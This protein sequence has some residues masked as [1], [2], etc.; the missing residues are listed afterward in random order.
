MTKL[1]VARLV[2]TA[3][4]IIPATQRFGITGAAAAVTGVYIFPMMPFDVYLVIQSV[5]TSL[6][7]LLRELSYPAVASFLMGGVVFWLQ[8]VLTLE[9]AILEFLILATVG[10]VIYGVAVAVLETQLRWG[11]RDTLGTFMSSI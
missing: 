10:A 4:V 5:E 7:R 9:W 2:L 6:T 8:G 3:I 11:L 1:G